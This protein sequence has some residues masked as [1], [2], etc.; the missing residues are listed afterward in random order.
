MYYIIYILFSSK[1]ISGGQ[2]RYYHPF[3]YFWQ[4]GGHLSDSV[5]QLV[6]AATGNHIRQPPWFQNQQLMS[7][8]GTRFISFAKSNKFNQGTRYYSQSHLQLK[9][10]VVIINWK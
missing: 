9:C 3:V 7:L 1:R 5:P 2:L 10:R 6:Q 4:N 8:S